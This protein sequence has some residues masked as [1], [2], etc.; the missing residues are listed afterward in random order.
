VL[1]I[2]PTLVVLNGLVENI[3]LYLNDLVALAFCKS[4]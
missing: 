4:H 3:G 1:A 2:G